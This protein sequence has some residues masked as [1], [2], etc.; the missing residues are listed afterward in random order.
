MFPSSDGCTLHSGLNLCVGRRPFESW[1]RCGW[2]W[3]AAPGRSGASR[4]CAD[5]GMR[6]GVEAAAYVSWPFVPG[7]RPQRRITARV[8]VCCTIGWHL[9]WLAVST[10]TQARCGGASYRC[11]M[12]MQS[13]RQ[14]A[15]SNVKRCGYLVGSALF[16]VWLVLTHGLPQWARWFP[17]WLGAVMWNGRSGRGG[18]SRLLRRRGPSRHSRTAMT[19]VATS[20]SSP[21]PEPQHGRN[22]R[23][24]R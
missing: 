24:H 17:L 8:R 12:A 14:A 11:G 16:R 7:L 5:D 21:V 23:A 2:T 9:N 20:S 1:G 6:R 15:G 22:G 19:P 18:V 3:Q 4:P 10:C 13:M